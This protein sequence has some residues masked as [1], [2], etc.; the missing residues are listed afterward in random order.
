MRVFSMYSLPFSWAKY[1]Y[2][3]AEKC[4]LMR[5]RPD[6]TWMVKNRCNFVRNWNSMASIHWDIGND[7]LCVVGG[8]Y[9]ICLCI[10]FCRYFFCFVRYECVYECVCVTFMW[11]FGMSFKSKQRKENWNKSVFHIVVSI[12]FVREL[13]MEQHK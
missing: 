4:L 7:V 5:I 8:I 3:L 11:T 10:C 12:H 1:V 6:Y 2:I 9:S 13:L